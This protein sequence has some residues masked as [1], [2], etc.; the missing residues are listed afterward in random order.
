M[1]PTKV[2]RPTP[3]WLRQNGRFLVRNGHGRGVSPSSGLLAF[4]VTLRRMAAE[5]LAHVARYVALTPAETAELL[6]YFAPRHLRKKELLLRQGEVAHHEAF[7]VR[8]CLRAYHT[9]A[10]GREHIIR[11]AAENWWIGDL[12]SFHHGTPAR[13]AIEALEDT[14]LLVYTKPDEEA[15]L[16]RLPQLETWFRQLYR[17]GI[18]ALQQRMLDTISQTADERYEDFLRRYPS[19]EQRVP[20]YLVA[21]YLGITP[22]FLSQ[23]RRKRTGG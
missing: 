8:G 3:G 14:D 7:V 13:Y 10:A 21:A 2:P 9:D 23:I 17:S 18:I 6:T 22:Q 16:A 12:G 19:L 1:N 15:L 11:F 4:S 5:F 20:Q